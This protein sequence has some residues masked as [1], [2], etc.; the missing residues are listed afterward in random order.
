VTMGSDGI[1]KLLSINLSEAEK[2][3]Q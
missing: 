1:S 2:V 3:A